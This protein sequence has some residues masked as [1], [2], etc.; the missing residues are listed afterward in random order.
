MLQNP[1]ASVAAT[2]AQ[3]LVAAVM[4]TRAILIGNAS[5]ICIFD[6]YSIVSIII[7]HLLIIGILKFNLRIVRV[8]VI[9]LSLPSVSFQNFPDTLQ[10]NIEILFTLEYYLKGLE[11]TQKVIQGNT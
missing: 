7:P 2:R 11:I 9:L 5:G 6:F 10:N 4:S 8:L 3:R 1:V